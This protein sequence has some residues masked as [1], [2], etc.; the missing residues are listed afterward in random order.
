MLDKVNG[1]F[2][3][4]IYDPRDESLFCARDHIGIKPFYY[5]VRDGVFS[6]ASEVKALVRMFGGLE[7]DPEAIADYIYLQ[8]VMGK[9]TFFKDV[10]RL[11]PGESLK[12]TLT[13]NII[14]RKY[15]NL[16]PCET[17]E[18]SFES[19]SEELQAHLK[20]SINLQLR[21]DV[22]L[23]AHLSGGLD[24]GSVAGIAAEKISPEKLHTFTAAFEEGG[25]FDDT[26]MASISS[27]HISSEHHQIFPT[28]KDF[29]ELYPKI[30]WHLDE[31]MAAEG[32]FP[33]YMVSK[34]AKENVTVVLG[35]Q[36]ADE[37]FGG[38][39]R[40]YVLL[41]L[42]ALRNGAEKGN[43]KLGLSWEEIGKSLGQLHNYGPMWKKVNSNT[44]FEAP[45]TAYWRMIDRSENLKK[46]L[47]EDFIKSLGGY[48]PF[49]TYME[50]V[51]KFENAELLNRI[52]FFET[53]C[54]LPA[55]LHIEDR[56]S[57]AVSL[58]SRVP[59]LDPLLIQFAFSLPSAIKMKD[60]RTKA[61]MRKAFSGY[62]AP[63]ISSRRDKLGFPVPTSR[64]F[65]GPLSGFMKDILLSRNS[66][67]RGIFK[68]SALR[69]ATDPRGDFDRSAWGILNLEM[70]HSNN[71]KP[72]N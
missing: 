65:A 31:P 39:T 9:K 58:E 60:G 17:Y 72:L 7:S 59:I 26:Q 2:A 53:S 68:E 62:L 12:I 67:S 22:P 23:G 55:L 3:F 71:L 18:G 24:T 47:E 5:T 37:I 1:M 16:N 57:M 15:W 66:L 8:Y 63:E 61:I 42:Q 50:Y 33:Q 64:W 19:A 36:G 46:T 35:G 28:W 44:A 11:L 43:E 45:E 40:Y 70:F 52:L 38:Y 14:T 69:S 41:L 56:M 51:D 4:A 6:F 25:V 21:S 30:I 13:G 29:E 54:W 32:V 10:F 34:L 49:D 48:N 27:R 20:R